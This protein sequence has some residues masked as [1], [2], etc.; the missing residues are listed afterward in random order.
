MQKVLTVA[1]DFPPRCASGVYRPTGLVKYLARLGWELTVL[2]VRASK[3]EV[4]DPTLLAKVPPQV[5]VVQTSYLSLA[6]WEDSAAKGLRFAGALQP[7]GRPSRSS[8]FNRALR[9]AASFVRSCMYFPDVFAGWIPFAVSKAIRLNR[10]HHFD[11]VYTTSP[12]RTSLAVGL[13]LKTLLRI[14]WVA[15]FRDP[16]YPAESHFRQA[17][18]RR[19]LRLILRIADSL[20]VVTEGFEQELARF[21]PQWANKLTLIR[22]GY[23][24]E[25]FANSEGPPCTILPSGYLHM[26]HLGTIYPGH[27]GNF[28]PALAALLEENPELQ[29][30]VRV[31]IIGFPD[32]AVKEFAADPTLNGIVHLR[33]FVHHDDALKFIVA[34][35]YL[36]IF[37]GDREFSRLAVS[38]KFY[39]YLRGGRPILALAYD[40]DL[41]RLI[42]TSGAGWVVDPEDTAAI[43]RILRTILQNDK[44]VG[45]SSPVSPEFVEQFR[46]DRLARKVAEV[47]NSTVSHGS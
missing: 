42:E 31:N 32:G 35:D 41:K 14:P 9:R 23:D 6:G 7:A 44:N 16:W 30:V 29:R 11:V 10:R 8:V 45:I 18:D 12:P 22:N 43:K 38:G 15:E 4:G 36:L 2:T 37:L 46:Y 17:M 28:F 20:V 21:Y 1:F 24:E 3:G 34:S 26:T 47:L 33:D 39:E 19:L 27:S 13:I 25:D 40:G 5:K